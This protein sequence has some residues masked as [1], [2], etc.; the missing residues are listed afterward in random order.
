M[1]HVFLHLLLKYSVEMCN[2]FIFIIFCSVSIV[3]NL[4]IRFSVGNL[5]CFI[6]APPPA[7]IEL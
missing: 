2:V 6:P 5:N 4:N 1:K 3:H 7:P